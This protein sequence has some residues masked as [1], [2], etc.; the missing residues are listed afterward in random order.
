[1][2]RADDPAGRGADRDGTIAAR[3][4]RPS[5]RSHPRRATSARQHVAIQRI[6]GAAALFRR[7][8]PRQRGRRA[9]DIAERGTG[10]PAL[11]LLLRHAADLL[12]ERFCALVAVLQL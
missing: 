11:R 10:G 6:E 7:I 3:A 9:Q 5:F 1:M 8:G 12:L 2:T 4:Y